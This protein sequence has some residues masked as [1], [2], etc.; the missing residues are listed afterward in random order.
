MRYLDM[1]IYEK[2]MLGLVNFMTVSPPDIKSIIKL[3]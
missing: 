1:W 2:G 3:E